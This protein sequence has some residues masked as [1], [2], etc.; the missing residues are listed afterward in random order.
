[1]SLKKVVIVGGHGKVALRLAGLIASKHS[2]T[3]IIRDPAH[4]ADLKA[5]STDITPLVLSLEDSPVSEFSSAFTD[6][7]TVV[8]SAG[9][10]GNGGAERTRKVDYEGAL[11][12]FDAI[13]AVAGPKPH[14]VLVSALDVRDPNK[15]PE[16]Y[17][18]EDK[19]V[20]ERVRSRIKDYMHW[21]YEADKNLVARTAFT[22]TIL[23]PGGLTEGPGTGK[24][25]IG[26]THM[27]PTIPRGDVANALAALV[28][29]PD[30]AGLAIDIVGG[31]TLI[32]EGIDAF[33]KKGV[34]DWLG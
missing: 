18:E 32:S 21:K 23:R 25:S 24:A 19:N 11:K 30:A 9:A 20:S 27:I 10:G 3:S 17:T 22:W 1:M 15:I 28:D 12:V 31:E 2:I 33:I 5:I 29:R 13:E 7:A 26:R 14:L 4:S 34:T 8:F 6:A 16:H